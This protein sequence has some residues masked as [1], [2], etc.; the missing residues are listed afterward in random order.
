[1]SSV[2]MVDADSLGAYMAITNLIIDRNE[3]TEFRHITE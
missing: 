1:M 3:A 2:W